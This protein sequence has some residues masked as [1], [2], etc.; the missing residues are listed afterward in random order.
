MQQTY[1]SVHGLSSSQVT[2]QVDVFNVLN[3]G[4]ALSVRSQNYTTLSYLQSSS[5]LQ[6]RILRVGTQLKW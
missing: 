5:V 2:T 6:G 3:R 1:M 4:D